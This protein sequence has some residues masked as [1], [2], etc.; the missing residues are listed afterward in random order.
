[1]KIK[2]EEFDA[3]TLRFT[4]TARGEGQQLFILKSEA[5]DLFGITEPGIFN[6][7]PAEKIEP[8]YPMIERVENLGDRLM[9]GKCGGVLNS[10]ELAEKRCH[11]CLA[12]LG[13]VVKLADIVKPEEE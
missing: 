13:R 3:H 10:N 11:R 7:P 1:M 12:H 2:V 9:C 8:R 5:C 4:Y 6:I